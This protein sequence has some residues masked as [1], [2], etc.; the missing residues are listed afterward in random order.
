MLFLSP[1][2][3]KKVEKNE[4]FTES[5]IIL[6]HVSTSIGLGLLCVGWSIHPHK[7]VRARMGSAHQRP[8]LC[9]PVGRRLPG[10]SKK[11]VCTTG[12]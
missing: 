9:W 3:Q 1:P 5:A 7:E 6:L 11:R 2:P 12:T 4:T 10:L 8:L